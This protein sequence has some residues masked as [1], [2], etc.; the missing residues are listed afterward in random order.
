MIEMKNLICDMSELRNKLRT[1][2][3]DYKSKG[4][5]DEA[6]VRQTIDLTL[7]TAVFLS[8][9]SA[10]TIAERMPCTRDSDHEHPEL[11]E[12]VIMGVGL[13]MEVVNQL[14]L[15][16]PEQIA[17]ALARSGLIRV[18]KDRPAKSAGLPS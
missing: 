3:S 4:K 1:E 10:E 17:K 7:E 14:G 16:S 9:F 18:Q 8:N 2:A 5:K 12:A 11:Y 6:E 13:W 15:L